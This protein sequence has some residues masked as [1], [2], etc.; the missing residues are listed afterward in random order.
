[1]NKRN[2]PGQVDALQLLYQKGNLSS[3]QLKT[4]KKF[5]KTWNLSPIDAIFETHLISEE[6]VAD[7]MAQYMKLERIQSVRARK[8]PV[9]VLHSVPFSAA[10]ALCCLP[11]EWIVPGRH[12][13]VAVADPTCNVLRSSLASHLTGSHGLALEITL[14]VGER[15]D[16]LSAIDLL[17]PLSLQLQDANWE[18]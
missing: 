10:R 14:A 7:A 5:M 1:M 3:S 15:R 2:E 6:G 16:I 9:N 11:L 13:K 17:Y 18:P 12:L 4:L 8:V